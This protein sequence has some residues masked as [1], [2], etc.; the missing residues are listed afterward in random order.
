[1]N[2]TQEIYDYEEGG[3]CPE[4]DGRLEYPPVEGCS[5]HISPPCNRCVTNPLTCDKCGWEEETFE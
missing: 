5:C 3:Q 2:Q 1:M 4:C